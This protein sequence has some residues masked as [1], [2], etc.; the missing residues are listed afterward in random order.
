MAGIRILDENQ[1]VVLDLGTR[2]FRLL[3]VQSIGGSNT[4]AVTV[5]GAQG[6]VRA[7]GIPTAA[8]GEPPTITVAGSTVSWDYDSAANRQPHDMYIMEY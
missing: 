7:V 3:T 8:T 1:N 4:G 6:T 5:T 2:L